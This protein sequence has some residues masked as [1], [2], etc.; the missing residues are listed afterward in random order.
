MLNGLSTFHYR[1][2][3]KQIVLE[4]QRA[5]TVPKMASSP[6]KPM[7]MSTPRYQPGTQPPKRRQFGTYLPQMHH[8]NIDNQLSQGQDSKDS[9][10]GMPP[11]LSS[12]TPITGNLQ[13][14]RGQMFAYGTSQQPSEVLRPSEGYPPCHDFLKENIENTQMMPYAGM[15]KPQDTIENVPMLPKDVW[16]AYRS[17]C[18]NE[19]MHMNIDTQYSY[20]NIDQPVRYKQQFRQT[21][22]RVTFKVMFFALCISYFLCEFCF[23]GMS[24]LLK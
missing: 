20:Y 5:H 8:F 15:W 6:W 16:Q 18:Y 21:G 19:Q 11:F 2:T 9:L 17:Q 22:K 10:I 1:H 24:L 14:P 3:G 23:F 4:V 13:K 7:S 12:T